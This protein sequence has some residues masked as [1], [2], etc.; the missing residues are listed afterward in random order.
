[1][2]PLAIHFGIKSLL[3]KGAFTYQ[4]QFKKYLLINV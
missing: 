2:Q 3:A 4:Q 1:M